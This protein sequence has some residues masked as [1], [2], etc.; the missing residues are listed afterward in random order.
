[1]NRPENSNSKR[2]KK[3]NHDASQSAVNTFTSNISQYHTDIL[4]EPRTVKFDY[5]V[6]ADI[7]EDPRK[8][9][10]VPPRMVKFDYRVNAD[11]LED[12]RKFSTVPSQTQTERNIEFR[13]K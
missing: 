4:E 7:L 6:N 8:F 10:T 12:P 1:L 5:R 11:I 2:N 9:S 3:D 13:R